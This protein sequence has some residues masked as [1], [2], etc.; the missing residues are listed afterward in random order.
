MHDRDPVAAA[1]VICV[2][3][4]GRAALEWLVKE[5]PLNSGK[6]PFLERFRVSSRC[7]LEPRNEAVL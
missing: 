6:F 2:Q 1:A 3:G 4:E 5:F 7:V